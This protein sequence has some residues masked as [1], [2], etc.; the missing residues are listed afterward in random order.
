MVL[1]LSYQYRCIGSLQLSVKI[2][3]KTGQTIKFTLSRSAFAQMLIN[4]KTKAEK[5]VDELQHK[6]F[7]GVR[8]Q[9]VTKVCPI[10]AEEF[11][12][13]VPVPTTSL[14]SYFLGCHL[15]LLIY[16]C[17]TNCLEPGQDQ[18]IPKAL[19]LIS[20]RKYLQ[21]VLIGSSSF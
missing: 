2:K 11:H 8:F 16:L 15:S 13:D 4:F 12:V 3:N 1:D 5:S 10:F 6:C 20:Q 9:N 7:V 21:W 18:W 14:S 19:F 17:N